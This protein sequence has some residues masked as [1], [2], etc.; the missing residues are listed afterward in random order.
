M[1]APARLPQ[2]KQAT[3][4]I[5]FTVSFNAVTL[6]TKTATKWRHEKITCMD[7][8]QIGISVIL[9]AV[10][11]LFIRGRPRYNVV[12]ILALLATA[13]AGLVPAQEVF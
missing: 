7:N 4:S 3:N 13:I 12:A 6:I 11:A 9:V 5:Y 2:C 1:V 10:V 8:S